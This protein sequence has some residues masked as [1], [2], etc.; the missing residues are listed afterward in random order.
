MESGIGNLLE[1]KV[2]EESLRRIAN[3]LYMRK[4]PV[5]PVLY[6][7][8]NHCSTSHRTWLRDREGRRNGGA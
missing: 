6:G 8:Y 2:L 4:Q 5:F 1:S 3:F 7:L